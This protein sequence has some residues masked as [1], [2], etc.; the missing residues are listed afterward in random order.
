MYVQTNVHR[1]INLKTYVYW[2]ILPKLST[3]QTCFR[4]FSKKNIMLR[5]SHP[6]KARERKKKPTNR[7]CKMARPKRRSSVL[8]RCWWL[9]HPL[10]KYWSNWIISRMFGLK[11]Q[12]IGNQH[13]GFH[14]NSMT[15]QLRTTNVKEIL[16]RKKNSAT[17]NDH[18]IKLARFTS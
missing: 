6:S 5:V 17:S 1:Q 8:L 12:N 13:V 10:K 3:L 18:N 7:V 2:F 4:V 15:P 11:M 14:L 16:G 9:N